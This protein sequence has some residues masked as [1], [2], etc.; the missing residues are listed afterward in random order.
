MSERRSGDVTEI[1]SGERVTGWRSVFSMPSAY[2]VSQRLI[3]ADRFRTWVVDHLLEVAPGESIVDIGCGT[4]DI[5]DDLPPCDYVGIDH[6]DRYI[7][8]AR[9][10]FGSRGTFVTQ[11]AADSA[12]LAERQ[13]S[14]VM[15][16]GVLHHL[17]DDEVRDAL[18]LAGRLLAPGGR[19]VSI[20]P[21]FTADQHPVARWLA[22]RD[23]GQFVRT[24]ER[25]E[26]LLS[27]AFA[28]VESDVKHDLLRV[29]Y[30]HVAVRAREP[31]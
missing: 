26:E 2:R 10:R 1:E 12:E 6:S 25:V 5:L 14:I 24:P 11:G 4:A 19:F 17:S 13:A 29:P 28:S 8:A 15:M 27:E 3:G 21:T 22:A 7:H 23:R 16:I 30:S 9:E 31:R 20:D 18:R